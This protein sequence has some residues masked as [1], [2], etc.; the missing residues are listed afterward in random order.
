MGVVCSYNR[1]KFG[2]YFGIWKQESALGEIAVLVVTRMGM[3]D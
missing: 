2:I 3:D 1:V